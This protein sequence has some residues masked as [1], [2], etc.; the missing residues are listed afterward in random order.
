MADERE[1]LS[2]EKVSLICGVS[3]YTVAYWRRE[4]LGPPCV[5]IGGTWRYE[6]TELYKWIDQRK[7]VI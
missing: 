3:P 7:D 1:Y 6:K 5:K 2:A 4:K